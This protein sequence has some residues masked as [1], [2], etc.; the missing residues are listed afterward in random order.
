MSIDKLQAKINE[1]ADRAL[2]LAIK[3]QCAPMHNFVTNLR[4]AYPGSNIPSDEIVKVAMEVFLPDAVQGQ[5]GYVE[6]KVSFSTYMFSKLEDTLFELTKDAAR[7][8]ATDEFLKKVETV[9]P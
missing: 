8:M 4:K 9:L 1:K 6:A 2:K 3:D 5:K 7:Q